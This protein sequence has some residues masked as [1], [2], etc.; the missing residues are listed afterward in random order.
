MQAQLVWFAAALGGSRSAACAR[1]GDDR[2]GQRGRVLGD[3]CCVRPGRDALTSR[4]PALVSA[5]IAA[6]RA[7]RAEQP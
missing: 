7:R 5:R 2:M 3:L 1:L 4:P 6:G